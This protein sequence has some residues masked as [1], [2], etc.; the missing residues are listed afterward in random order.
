MVSYGKRDEKSIVFLLKKAFGTISCRFLPFFFGFPTFFPLGSF[1]LEK[2]ADFLYDFGKKATHP[3][4]TKEEHPHQDLIESLEK[5]YGKGI[6][7]P[8][9]GVP[10]TSSLPMLSTGSF[11]LNRALGVGGF[12]WGRIVE[13]YGPES[14]GKTT[15]ALHAIKSAQKCGHDALFIDAEHA[16]DRAYG[17]ALGINLA[18]LLICQ[19]DYGE[20]ALDIAHQAIGEGAIKL[21]VIDSVSAL[22]PAS[23]LKGEMSAP[24]MGGQARMMSKA[25]RKLAA[26][27]HKA[28]ALCIFINQIRHKI[29]LVFGPTETTSGG[30]ALKFYASIRLKVG[31]GIAIKGREG[32]FLGHQMKIKVVKNKVAPPFKEALV[33]IRYGEG[34]DQVGELI[35]QALEKGILTQAKSWYAFGEKKI[36][37]G[38]ERLRLLLREDR[39]FLALIEEK[40]QRERSAQ[41]AT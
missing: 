9:G 28:Q 32:E 33:D 22:I 38:R 26:T 37:Q 15:L 39:D 11:R 30:N 16:F 24:A 5:K 34:I 35:G 13:I 29:G 4:V 36:A 17:K 3:M 31:R 1:F 14:S 2:S 27:L 23:E 19:P 10:V 41:P 8:L 12:P 40:L 21:V 6:V 18:Q 7:M 20:Q 25:L